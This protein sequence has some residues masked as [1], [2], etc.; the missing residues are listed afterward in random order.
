MKKTAAFLLLITALLFVFCA[1]ASAGPTNP[2]RQRVLESIRR[3][4]KASAQKSRGTKAQSPVEIDL[5]VSGTRAVGETLTFSANISGLSA[6]QKVSFVGWIVESDYDPDST[7]CSF[8]HEVANATGMTEDSFSYQFL[9][10][11]EYLV[12]FSVNDASTENEEVIEQISEVI[13][14][15]GDYTLGDKIQEI[16]D[17]CRT[18]STWQFALNMYNWLINHL[19]YDN[20]LEYYGPDAMIRGTG[21]CDSYSKSF[22]LLCRKAGIPV[23][24]ATSIT[25]AW[26]NLQLDGEWYQVDATWDD[27]GTVTGGSENHE[28]FCL[29]SE[30][31]NS[32]KDH[33]PD[34][35]TGSHTYRCTSLEDNYYIYK[36]LWREWGVRKSTGQGESVFIPYT[37]LV[38]EAFN[39]G[40]VVWNCTDRINGSYYIRDRLLVYAIQR[41][42][43]VLEDGGPVL[44]KAVY[45][46]DYYTFS[47]RGWN[48]P[49]PGVLS[50]PS[51]VETVEEY[52]FQGV[53]ASTVT[54]PPELRTVGAKAFADSQVRTVYFSGQDVLLDSSAFDGCERLIFVTD[55]L[56][57]I[58]YADEHGYLVISP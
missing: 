57:A 6:E 43:A 20:N 47:I 55:N 27:H 56:S 34:E 52:A 41:E 53:N 17:E 54:M 16:V 24:R 32:I 44:V 7:G 36:G 1:A 50:L 35:Y 40:N 42:G 51:G 5:S 4:Q 12:I 37:D 31:M 14:I 46:K 11:G 33:S 10:A 48:I 28:F 38:T 22:M 15:S 39:R 18:A 2:K 3:Y 9:Y 13:T 23:E 8:Y 58:D 49:N 25:H 21:V 26:N 29:N 45:H 19:E 30:I